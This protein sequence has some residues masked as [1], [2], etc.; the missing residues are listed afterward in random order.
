MRVNRFHAR[1]YHCSNRFGLQPLGCELLNSSQRLFVDPSRDSSFVSPPRRIIRVE[2]PDGLGRQR[3]SAIARN[4][5]ISYE[6]HLDLGPREDAD[7]RATVIHL[8]LHQLFGREA[9]VYHVIRNYRRL[10]FSDDSQHVLSP[11]L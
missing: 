9:H 5:V 2:P 3:L 8:H 4:A 1:S 6:F 7:A 11:P 10:G